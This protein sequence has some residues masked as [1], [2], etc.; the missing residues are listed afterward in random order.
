MQA[1][2]ARRRLARELGD[3]RA[4]SPR[5]FEGWAGALRAARTSR[6]GLDPHFDA[7]EAFLASRPTP[8]SVQGR[9]NL[10]SARAARSS[11]SRPSRS[12]AT[13]AAAAA[14]ASA[15]RLA[16]RAPSSRWTSPTVPAAIRAARAFTPRCAPS[17]CSPRD[18][19]VT[20]VRG[21]VVAPFSGRPSPRSRSGRK[22]RVLSAAAWRAVAAARERA[23]NGSARS[24]A[25]AVPSRRRGD[26]VFPER[27]DPQ[28]GAT[29]GMQSLHFLHEGFKLETLWAPP[30]V[31]A[32]RMPGAGLAL[33]ERLAEIPYA[34]IVDAIASCHRSLGTVR[35]RRRGSLEPALHWRLHEDDLP[36][37]G[38]ALGVIVDVLFA[39]GARKALPGVH[40]IPDELAPATLGAGRLRR[41]RP[42]TRDAAITP[43]APPACMA[44]RGRRGGRVGPLP[45]SRQSLCGGHGCVPPLHIREPDAHRHGPRAPHGGSAGGPA[46]NR[47]KSRRT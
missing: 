16:A 25:P 24:G 23:R 37:L 10:C 22:G 6:E 36:V 32:V 34:S 9:R 2:R 44:T 18:G 30:A 47:K 1:I 45:R 13:C 31:L 4:A 7:V 28:F 5:S 39:A 21:R 14:A 46:L 38:R 27:V 41:F 15:H 43:S 35:P 8:D 3:R 33:K 12:R 19:R 40:G 42:T 17:R 11:A 26:G 29:Q 20:G